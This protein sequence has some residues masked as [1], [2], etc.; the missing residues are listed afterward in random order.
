[1][2][3]TPF[4]SPMWPLPPPLSLVRDDFNRTWLD[5][6]A[7][8]AFAA[9]LL[10]PTA[11]WSE[12]PDAYDLSIDVHGFRRRDVELEL[13][14][15]V[16]DIHAERKSGRA[17]GFW[18]SKKKPKEHAMIHHSITLPAGADRDALQANFDDGYLHVHVPKRPEARA[19]TI[20]IRVNGQLPRSASS[21][22]AL[23]P[24]PP[25][26][27]DDDDDRKSSTRARNKLRSAVDSLSRRLSGGRRRSAP[28]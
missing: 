1:M 25:D 16:L 27:D 18:S 4:D 9:L 20:P 15:N 2:W 8:D 22:H 11:R 5:A 12:S 19:R 10:P 23:P 3:K 6:F 26:R 24:A 21:P 13:R 7:R 28:K 14:G 17:N